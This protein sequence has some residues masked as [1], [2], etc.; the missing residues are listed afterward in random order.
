MTTSTDAG[1]YVV[2]Y[3]TLQGFAKNDGIGLMPQ[4][5]VLCLPGIAQGKTHEQISQDQ[6]ISPVSVTKTL[7]R[8]Y[9][10]LSDYRAGL[11]VRSAAQAVF[12]AM[13]RGIIAPLAILLV[14]SGPMVATDDIKRSAQVKTGQQSSGCGVIAMIPVEDVAFIVAED[15][16]RQR[17]QSGLARHPNP[18][19]PDYP[20]CPLCSDRDPDCD[21]CD[22]RNYEE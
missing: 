18:R 6:N 9:D 3:G 12:E 11:V 7:Q 13:R 16:L 15:R 21:I 20:A 22:G 5:Q 10:K 1:P 17:Y 4:R 8:A 2:R 14:L 19:D